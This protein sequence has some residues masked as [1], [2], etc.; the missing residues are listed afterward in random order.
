MNAAGNCEVAKLQ[1][2]AM[3][4][5]LGGGAAL[6]L[7]QEMGARATLES[8]GGGVCSSAV[9]VSWLKDLIQ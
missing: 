3:E 5:E 2:A 7:E 9:T 6:E 8:L 4:L 1:T